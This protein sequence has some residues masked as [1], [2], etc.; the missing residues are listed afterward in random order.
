MRFV[1]SWNSL[2]SS[3]IWFIL[4]KWS[5]S[6]EWKYYLLAIICWKLTHSRVEKHDELF[7]YYIWKSK[8]WGIIAVN[9][10]LGI[11][12]SFCNLFINIYPLFGWNFIDSFSGN[13][14]LCFDVFV[15]LKHP[16]YVILL[17]LV[18]NKLNYVF[19]RLVCYWW[20]HILSNIFCEDFFS[21]KNNY[22]QMHK[23]QKIPF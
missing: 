21:F 10:H 15:H 22:N 17:G 23:M 9:C 19:I 3:K 6:S 16:V 2:R 8:F 11:F 1:G 5:F 18:K 14:K 20:I 4:M 12:C 13:C 7:F